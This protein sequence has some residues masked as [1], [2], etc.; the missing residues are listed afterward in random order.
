MSAGRSFMDELKRR[1]VIRVAGL[2]LV[3]AWL[4]TQVIGTVLPMFGAPEWIARSVVIALAIGFVPALIFAWVFERTAQGL[5]HDDG[6]T[7]A[8]PAAAPSSRRSGAATR[9]R[10]TP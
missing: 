6:P 2:Y 10:G 7:P 4:V 5:Q 8:P 9:L 1:N 3:A